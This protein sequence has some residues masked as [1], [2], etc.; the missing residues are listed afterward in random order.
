MKIDKELYSKLETIVETHI[1]NWTKNKLK[2]D[3]LQGFDISFVTN[4][5][6]K[7]SQFYGA[8]NRSLDSSLGCLYEK[9]IEQIS[10]YYNEFTTKKLKTINKSTKAKR[11]SGYKVDLLF[12]RNGNVFIFELKLHC[13]LD[14]KKAKAEKK[15]LKIIKE[16]YKN[17]INIDENNIHPFLGV[18]GNKDGEFPNDFKMGRLK[19]AFDRTEILVEKE[20]FDFV[21]G[22]DGFFTEFKEFKSKFID[23]KIYESIEVIKKHYKVNE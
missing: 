10:I 7:E 11:K 13:K 18:I 22:V 23:P 21:S 9:L 4:G 3:L 6:P 5:F 19:E 1:R 2:D 12:H 15:S 14:N 20:L 17:E 8:I 16:A